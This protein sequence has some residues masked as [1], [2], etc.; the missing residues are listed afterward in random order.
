MSL[1]GCTYVGR[2][3]SI[4][5]TIC[6]GNIEFVFKSLRTCIFNLSIKNVQILSNRCDVKKIQIEFTGWI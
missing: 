5:K 3:I 4:K 2:Y 6:E 1:N